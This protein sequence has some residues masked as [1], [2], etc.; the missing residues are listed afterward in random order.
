MSPSELPVTVT[1]R[2]KASPLEIVDGGFRVVARGFGRIATDLKPGLYKARTR[3][4]AM[5]EEEI[6]AVDENQPPPTVLLDP[7]V[8]PS[9]IPLQK[10]TAPHEHHQEAV[11]AAAAEPLIRPGAGSSLL[12]SLRDAGRGPSEQTAATL[13]A[14]ARSFDGFD[15]CAADGTELIDYDRQAR[16]DIEHGFAILHAE[17]D[18]GPYILRFRRKGLEPL[19]LPIVTAAGWA[20]QLF[21]LLEG[22]LPADAVR[23]PLL[24]DAA[25]WMAPSGQPF[26]PEA[27]DFRLTEVARQGLQR[28]RNI[29]DKPFMDELI[30]GKFGNPM[31]GLFAAHLLLLDPEPPLSLLHL[32]TD[33]LENM[34]GGGF[35]D[36][37]AL[38]RHLHVLDRSMP[39]TTPEPPPITFPPM[40]R[41]GWDMAA[42]L[43][44]TDGN[45]FPTDSVSRRIADRLADNGIW[46]AWRPR[47]PRPRLNLLA[48]EEWQDNRQR[49]AERLTAAFELTPKSID[50]EGG[51]PSYRPHRYLNRSLTQKKLQLFIQAAEL[52][53]G[54]A[55]PSDL[56]LRLARY[57]PW[58]E[59]VRKLTE[60]DKNGAISE[61]LS[62]VQKSLLPTLVLLRRQLDAGSEIDRQEVER[63]LAAFNLP[64][65]VLL[66]NLEE[67]AQIAAG[68]MANFG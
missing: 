60:L 31:L 52:A 37:N 15:L 22:D 54:P 25:L 55:P 42:G 19:A 12:L 33:N 59:L 62:S 10:T 50:L 6:F 34:L 46:T 39:P 63:M 27:R 51:R 20:S 29:L 61:Q 9:P 67:L 17:L 38:R 35:P 8:F 23:R 64:Q 48:D 45:L 40:L 47:Q 1:V 36:V 16:R 41:A 49:D 26:Q 68:A 56:L 5:V 58:Q 11:R 21:I 53:G 32:V 44:V 3:V 30:G 24:A 66:D 13:P 18:P 14:Y 57:F 2:D 43:S 4:G 65:S 28:G 7:V